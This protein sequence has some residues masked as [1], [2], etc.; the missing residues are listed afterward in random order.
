MTLEITCKKCGKLFE[1][2]IDHDIYKGYIK[3]TWLYNAKY[4]FPN[5]TDEEIGL[6]KIGECSKC[7]EK[8]Q[9]LSILQGE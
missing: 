3:S 4:L 5:L 2:N 6:L 7:L 1:I 9:S 8:D